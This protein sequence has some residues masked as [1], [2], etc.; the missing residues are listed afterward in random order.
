MDI[1]LKIDENI[2]QEKIVIYAKKHTEEISNIID[3][4]SKEDN[5]KIVGYI[6]SEVFIIEIAKVWSFYTEANKVFARINDKIYRI[7]YRLYEIEEIIK[8]KN[9]IKISNS[10]IVNINYIE[11]LDLGKIGTVIFKFKDGS[12]TYASRRSI[13]KI[14]EYLNLWGG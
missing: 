5:S 9:F 10:E 3:R 13:K 6:D 2:E 8:N 14:K 1:E 4:I 7:K 11:S 12:T